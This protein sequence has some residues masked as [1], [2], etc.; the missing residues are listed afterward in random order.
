M[1]FLHKIK[2][3]Q[4][5]LIGLALLMVALFFDHQTIDIHLVFK[6]VGEV[7]AL[8]LIVGVLHFLFEH[9]LRQ[10]MLKD[11]LHTIVAGKRI[12]D[13]GIVDFH[14]RSQQINELEENMTNWKEAKILIVGVHY[15]DSFIKQQVEVFQHRCQ[16]AKQTKVILLNPD[17]LGAN[18]LRHI[19]LKPGEPPPDVVP[20]VAI[21]TRFLTHFDTACQNDQYIQFY[22]HNCVLRYCFI[23]TE[24]FIWINLFLN[25]KGAS[26]IPAFKVKAK[27]P[28]YN[29]FWGDI[30]RLKE[31]SKHYVMDLDDK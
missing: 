19:N 27:S 7:G 21:I 23:A 28:I 4:L 10:A 16:Q 5:A 3:Y 9:N 12:V 15:D 26:K 13:N 30:Q 31:Q 2:T 1:D 22:L 29:L 18:Y 6:L 20:H 8:L 11:L 25:S 14:E 17:S 24:D